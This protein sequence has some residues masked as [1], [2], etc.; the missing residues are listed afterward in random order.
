MTEFGNTEWWFA[1]IMICS[2]LLG[3]IF[4]LFVYYTKEL[5]AHPMKLIMLL[6]LS[7]SAFQY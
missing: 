2:V 5:Q 7:E 6:A 1:L 4:F 3:L